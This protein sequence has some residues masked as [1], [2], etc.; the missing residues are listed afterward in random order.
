[1]IFSS[2]VCGYFCSGKNQ[3]D[4]I[5]LLSKK[6]ALPYQVGF[7]AY[8][9]NQVVRIFT[10]CQHQLKSGRATFDGS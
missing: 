4:T 5:F 8:Y 7:Q 9:I 1:M 3:L 2:F 6:K 10:K